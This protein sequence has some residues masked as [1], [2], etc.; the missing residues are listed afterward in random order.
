MH[1]PL[2]YPSKLYK[3]LG[4]NIDVMLL[5]GYLTNTRE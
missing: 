3:V 4:N 2:Q 5:V 1:Q